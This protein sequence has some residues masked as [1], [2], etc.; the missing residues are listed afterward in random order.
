MSLIQ[1][2]L[3]R[4]QLEEEGALPTNQNAPHPPSAEIQQPPTVSPPLEPQITIPIPEAVIPP[5]AK[6]TST[7][8]TGT[9]S[10]PTANTENNKP[11]KE[12][13]SALPAIGGMILLVIILLASVAGSIIYGLQYFGIVGPWRD[14]GKANTELTSETNSVE[15]VAQ[16]VETTTK[17]ASTSNSPLRKAV[18]VR[19]QA[20]DTTQPSHSTETKVPTENQPPQ[21]LPQGDSV[22]KIVAIP[23]PTTDTSSSVEQKTI[24]TPAPKQKTPVIWPAAKLQGIVGS[25]KGGAVMI[26]KNVVGVNEEIDGILVISIEPKGVWLE[27]KEERRFLKVGKSLD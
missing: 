1:E 20:G 23:D 2:A 3:K 14:S 5:P 6:T 12:K 16:T 26:N 21:H 15:P 10:S 9:G 25:G 27:H 4:Q 8:A 19:K 22:E 7:P 13:S 17:T 11:E 24:A 18:A